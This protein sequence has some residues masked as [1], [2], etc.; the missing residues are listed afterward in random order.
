[1]KTEN[2]RRFLEKSHSYNEAIKN[3]DF[4][5]AVQSLYQMALICEDEQKYAD[6]LKMFCTAY[7]IYSSVIVPDWRDMHVLISGIRRC[8]EILGMDMEELI[9]FYKRTFSGCF[10]DGTEAEHLG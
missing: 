1:M 8:Q 6:A 2:D 4:A 7:G 5:A 10:L 3:G 9:Y